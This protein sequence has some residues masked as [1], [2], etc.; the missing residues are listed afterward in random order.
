M[1]V[2]AQFRVAPMIRLRACHFSVSEKVFAGSEDWVPE[3][4]VK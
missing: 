3:H 4:S 2:S 1:T